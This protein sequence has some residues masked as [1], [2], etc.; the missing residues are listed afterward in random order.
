MQSFKEAFGNQLCEFMHAPR[1]SAKTFALDHTLPA[2]F[3]SNPTPVF[4]KVSIN[5]VSVLEDF[6]KSEHHL[7]AMGEYREI[8]G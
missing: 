6:L 8:D 5:A 2:Y 4:I 3:S 1:S 7:G